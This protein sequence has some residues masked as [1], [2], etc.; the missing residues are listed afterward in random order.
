MRSSI[1]FLVSDFLCEGCTAIVIVATY[2]LLLF[3]LP[4]CF[5]IHHVTFYCVDFQ[6]DNN[7]CLLFVALPPLWITHTHAYSHHVRAPFTFLPHFPPWQHF[8]I[9]IECI[10]N[11][12]LIA[13]RAVIAIFSL[14]A[15]KNT[16]LRMARTPVR[17]TTHTP[18]HTHALLSVS[19]SL[20]R[21]HS[22]N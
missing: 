15:A 9:C 16:A 8:C 6:N 5:F 13:I 21:K 11:G 12:I 2:L 22:E 4:P 18:T 20:R 17:V 19:M 7:S 14:I 1:I 10:F 3:C